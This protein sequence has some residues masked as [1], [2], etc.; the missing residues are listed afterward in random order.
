MSA[1]QTERPLFHLWP[2]DE[3][4]PALL[5][6][7]AECGGRLDWH[8]TARGVMFRAP[9][10]SEGWAD[11]DRIHAWAERL[12]LRGPSTTAGTGPTARI[13]ARIGNRTTK[14]RAS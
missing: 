5:A 1:T 3:R 10:T 7:D 11:L 2:D 13:R 6:L 9:R 14:G 8:Y 4:I 12:G